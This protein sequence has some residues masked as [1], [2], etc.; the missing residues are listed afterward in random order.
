MFLKR[1]VSGETL[2]AAAAA[3]FEAS[4]SFD[5]SANIAGIVEAGAFTAIQHGDR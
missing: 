2:A 1:L 3:A 5:L 4:A